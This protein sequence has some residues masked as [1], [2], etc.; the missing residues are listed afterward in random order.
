MQKGSIYMS[1]VI[2][3]EELMGHKDKTNY[4]K[5][6]KID[7]NYTSGRPKIIFDGED[8]ASLKGYN[9]IS[10]YTPKAGDRVLLQKVAGT[11]II[12]GKIM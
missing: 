5:L 10:S 6:G 2:R 7:S 3:I 8:V 1:E 9:Y 11:Y 4:Y 12:L